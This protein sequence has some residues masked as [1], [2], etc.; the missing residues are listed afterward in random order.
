M[1]KYT[2]KEEIN[3]KF[4]D[5]KSPAALFTQGRYKKNEYQSDRR[6]AGGII[7]KEELKQGELIKSE[8]I[9]SMSLTNDTYNAYLY[10]NIQVKTNENNKIEEFKLRYPLNIALEIIRNCPMKGEFV[11]DTVFYFI[12]QME[13]R[14]LQDYLYIVPKSFEAVK[15][16]KIMDLQKLDKKEPLKL[17]DL[18]ENDLL[19]YKDELYFVLKKYNALKIRTK[20]H[21]DNE[22]IN[23]KLTSEPAIIIYKQDGFNKA[24]INYQYLENHVLL[25]EKNFRKEEYG[26][27]Q[28]VSP[29]YGRTFFETL[30]VKKLKEDILKVISTEKVIQQ[31]LELQ[32]QINRNEELVDDKGYMAMLKSKKLNS[33]LTFNSFK[34][35]AA[36]VAVA[37]DNTID[38]LKEL[39]EVDELKKKPWAKKEELKVG[40]YYSDIYKDNLYYLGHYYRLK[41]KVNVHVNNEDYGI[42]FESIDEVY[43][44]EDRNRRRKY[45]NDVQN[46]V[47]E[48]KDCSN[49]SAK[50]NR[51]NSKY[52]YQSSVFALNRNENF[53]NEI[54]QIRELVKR[55]VCKII[56]N[57]HE[58]RI[59]LSGY[60]TFF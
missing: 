10:F 21:I 8:N 18:K 33:F 3:M 24:H 22:Y 55:G 52:E 49:L 26:I 29:Q 25:T 58:L 48:S 27:T 37:K 6:E 31:Y 39:V 16:G 41:P 17:E 1:S 35:D 45:V 7:K 28:C 38:I 42:A 59:I 56:K 9:I 20:R 23:V 46:Y 50:K 12:E 15:T 14:T 2:R 54:K 47:K 43:I 11:D 34:K 44:F 57:Q 5:Y 30:E 32:I 40:N 13:E 53:F 4:Y 51:Y 60:L 19:L 36:Y